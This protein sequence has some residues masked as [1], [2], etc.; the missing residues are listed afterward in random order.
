[1]FNKTALANFYPYLTGK[2]F[3][4]GKMP[5]KFQLSTHGRLGWLNPLINERVSTTDNQ[6]DTLRFG[7][8][9]CLEKVPVL[10]V[11]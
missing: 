3:T 6:V 4:N 5:I 9:R 8:V 7:L 11:G 1:M 2:M 10:R